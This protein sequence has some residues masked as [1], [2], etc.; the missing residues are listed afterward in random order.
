MDSIFQFYTNSV[1]VTCIFVFGAIV[2]H[3]FLRKRPSSQLY[4]I[5][6]FVLVRL[7]V[8]LSINT[9]SEFGAYTIPQKV[10]KVMS[11]NSIKSPSDILIT[12]NANRIETPNKVNYYLI[13]QVVWFLGIICFIIYYFLKMLLLNKKMKSSFRLTEYKNVWMW[14]DN[15]G[16]CVIG[17]F[18][19]RI[20]V[21]LGCKG[22]SLDIIVRHEAQHIKHF[23]Y[24]FVYLFYFAL[25]LNWYNPLVWIAYK[26]AIQDVE[27]ACDE[28]VL[29]NSTVGERQAYAR[30]LVELFKD[31]SAKSVVVGFGTSNIMKRIK[32]IGENKPK[33]TICTVFI[34]LICCS[35]FGVCAM[36][37]VKTDYQKVVSAIGREQIGASI[38]SVIYAD[39]DKCIF[40]DYHGV[41]IYDFTTK[42]MSDYIAFSEIGFSSNIQGDN[43]TFV[44]SRESGK[45]VYITN[46][47]KLYVYDCKG[48]RGNLLDYST[49]NMP[50]DTVDSL[51]VSDETENNAISQI[52]TLENNTKLYWKYKGSEGD[53]SGLRLTLNKNGNIEE[54]TIFK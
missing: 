37:H 32:N 5:W 3:F 14:N 30:V 31:T 13:F 36:L 48:K 26:M 38:P 33:K 50:T 11:N 39:S 22:E 34:V 1:F 27:K 29:F 53:Y 54:Y 51:Q 41:F 9:D 40:Y 7:L 43:A 16:A 49:T 2:L 20:Y 10:N 8:P 52:Y 15:T 24:L 45:I 42:K 46:Y 19:P 21:P 28:R 6:L 4:L 47:T 23:D 17:L 12:D 25:A 44:L 18:H 35:F